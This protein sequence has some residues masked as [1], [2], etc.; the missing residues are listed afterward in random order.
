MR[1]NL[2]SRH[3]RSGRYITSDVICKVCRQVLGWYYEH[4][5]D[6]SQKEKEGKVCL[7]LTKLRSGSEQVEENIEIN[8]GNYINFF[9]TSNGKLKSSKPYTD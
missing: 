2:G 7:E 4:A 1:E 5:F 8:S 3:L 6:R 9:L